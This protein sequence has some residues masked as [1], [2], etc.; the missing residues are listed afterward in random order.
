MAHNI[1]WKNLG[2]SY[3]QTEYFVRTRYSNGNWGPISIETDPH[4][5]IHVASTCL[6]YGQACFEGL[7]VFCQKDG[8]FSVFRYE[9]NAKRLQNSAE[10]IAMNA[11][12]QELFFQMLKKLVL[13]NKAF[14]PPYGTGASLY[15]RPL[16]IGSSPRIGLGPSA[17]FDFYMIAIPVGPYY[18]D[19]FYPVR[20]CVQDD[21][22]RAAPLG[23]GHVKVAGNY[24]S[25]IVGDLHIRSQGYP[26]TLYLDSAQ[27]RYIDEFSTSNFFG[28][29][30]QG[31]YVTPLSTSI[32]PSITNNS[33][34]QLAQ[35]QGME[36]IRRPIRI[37]ELDSF[38]EVGACGTAAVVTPIC[39]I[40]RGDT[41]WRFGKEDEAGET[42]KHFFNTIQD[43]QYGDAPDTFGWM[44]PI[45]E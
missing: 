24:A 39:S 37:D 5:S 33:L 1:D 2:F 34:I 20:A 3:M 36:V 12:S 29:T 21:F 25:A 8:T 13:L 42:T 27:H 18:K 45:D 35:K 43:I 28:I 26:I 17:E 15:I 11:P 4:I 7:K 6:H 19:G 44:T 31:Q 32:L 22:D 14:V 16:L 40:T 38:I 41:V 30:A 9:E 10:R 23:V